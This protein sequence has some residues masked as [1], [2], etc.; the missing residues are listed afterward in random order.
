MT[1]VLGVDAAVFGRLAGA[2][3]LA[4]AARKASPVDAH[5][6]MNSSVRRGQGPLRRQD[7]LG[8]PVD[9]GRYAEFDAG[10]RCRS[11]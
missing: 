3:R 4:V 8:Q 9:Q 6:A 11:A 1:G 2:R 10:R 7:G 5:T